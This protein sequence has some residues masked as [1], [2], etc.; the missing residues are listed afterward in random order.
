MSRRYRFTAHPSGE[1]LGEAEGVDEEHAFDALAR[2]KGYADSIELSDAEP[3][4]RSVRID[5]APVVLRLIEG[6]KP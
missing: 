1:V 5:P 2:A 6:G 4:Y 3:V